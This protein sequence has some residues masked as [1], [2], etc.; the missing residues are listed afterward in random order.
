MVLC[1]FCVT[2]GVAMENRK[3]EQQLS[4]DWDPEDAG[5]ALPVRC[6]NESIDGP[7]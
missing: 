4:P 3:Q 6:N 1:L 5:K 2:H 7:L